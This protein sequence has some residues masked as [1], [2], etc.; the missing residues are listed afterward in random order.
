[1]L[2]AHT[3]TEHEDEDV[4]FMHALSTLESQSPVAHGFGIPQGV[5]PWAK[6][7]ETLP[8]PKSW[9]ET[10]VGTRFG[11]WFQELLSFIP[12]PRRIEFH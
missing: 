10:F 1:M 6:S 3:H 8:R 12:L 9:P 5:S 11:W 2:Q 7:T 4:F